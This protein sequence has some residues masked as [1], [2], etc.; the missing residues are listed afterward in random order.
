M[1]GNY[2][3]KN[4]QKSSKWIHNQRQGFDLTS[5]VWQMIVHL[6]IKI[7]LYGFLLHQL[8]SLPNNYQMGS[9]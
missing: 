7:S 6:Q 1:R 8:F 5:K 3:R 4:A 2:K 9:Y